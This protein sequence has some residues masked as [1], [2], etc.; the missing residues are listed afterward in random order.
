[1]HA[2]QGEPRLSVLPSFRSLMHK[3]SLADLLSISVTWLVVGYGGGSADDQRTAAITAIIATA[4]W[5]T[6]RR[7]LLLLPPR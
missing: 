5:H 3:S 6:G 7:P 1:M 2:A 4:V